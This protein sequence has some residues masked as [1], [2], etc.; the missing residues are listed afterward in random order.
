MKTYIFKTNIQCKNCLSK[1][2]PFLDKEKGIEKWS[3]DLTSDTK[4]LTVN[5]TTLSA[6]DIVKLLRKVGFVAEAIT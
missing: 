5:T 3:I 1:V 4:Q 2:K 6:D